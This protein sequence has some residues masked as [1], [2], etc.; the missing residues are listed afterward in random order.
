MRILYVSNAYPPAFHGG[1]ELIAHFHAKTLLR[2]GH[3]ML[4]FA[5]D[6]CCEPTPVLRVAK[7]TYEGV[8]VE[9]VA[10]CTK[11]YGAATVNFYNPQVESLF[12][13]TLKEFHPDVVHFHNILGFSTGIIG[14]ARRFGAKTVVTVHDPWVFCLNCTLLRPDDQVCVDYTECSQC[15]AFLRDDKGRA[16]PIRL[17]NDFLRQQF[18][19][20]DVIV[21]PSQYL[22]RRYLK[23]GFPTDRVQVIGNGADIAR[24]GHLTKS[25]APEGTTRFTFIGY[26]GHHKGVM[27]LLKALELL[28]PGSGVVM[29]IVGGGIYDDRVRAV[30]QPLADRCKVVVW[31][32]VPNQ[33]IEEVF[34][35]TD[36]LISPSICAENQPGTVVEAMAT[37]TPVIASRLGGGVELV[38]DGV[39][40]LLF[41]PGNAAALAQRMMTLVKNRSQLPAMGKAGRAKVFEF[42]FENQ[43]ETFLELYREPLKTV[44]WDDAPPLILCAGES[45]SSDAFHAIDQFDMKVPVRFALA[46][47]FPDHFPANTRALWLVDP[48][49]GLARARQAIAANIPLLYPAS[50]VGIRNLCEVVDRD[51]DSIGFAYDSIDDMNAILRRLTNA[52]NFTRRRS[53]SVA[54]SVG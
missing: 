48:A 23:A 27:S 29:N 47:W 12:A 18:D 8:N 10:I 3:D 5:A 1:A 39:T 41:E 24:Y 45:V 14:Q 49:A 40:G 32:R 17:R 30:V 54:S 19:S 44:E 4:A 11:G 13:K 25:P 51:L 38:D 9:R 2:R 28:P 26:L 16:F 42:S 15:Q 53:L 22:A 46:D 6:F 50:H 21:S 35:Q 52:D 37:A 34:Q 36:V 43:A 7:S 31:G 33:R 20:P